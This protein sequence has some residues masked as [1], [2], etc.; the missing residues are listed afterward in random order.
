VSND[1]EYYQTTFVVV[2]FHG[3]FKRKYI[4]ANGLIKTSSELPYEHLRQFLTVTE[5][6]KFYSFDHSKSFQYVYFENADGGHVTIEY[7]VFT[8]ET[9]EAVDKM[10]AQH[11]NK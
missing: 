2:F 10:R 9:L 1:G 7:T 11:R 3:F 4:S 6:A 5:M 8:K